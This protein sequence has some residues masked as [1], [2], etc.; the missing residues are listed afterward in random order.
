M[1]KFMG[2]RENS[3]TMVDN[4]LI[5][6]SPGSKNPQGRNFFFAKLEKERPKE[7]FIELTCVS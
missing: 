2:K 4:F 7:L 3:K 5:T 6:T 1:K